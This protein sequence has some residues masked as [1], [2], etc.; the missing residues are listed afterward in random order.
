MNSFIE[1][2]RSN[3]VAR[4]SFALLVPAL[5]LA[6]GIA[7]GIGAARA[8]SYLETRSLWFSVPPPPSEA[9]GLIG[10]GSGCVYVNAVD[11][12][13]HYYCESRD[14]SEGIWDR[15]DEPPSIL[16]GS[17]TEDVFPE[18]P[19]GT[20]EVVE[21]CFGNEFLDASSFALLDDGTIKIY[22][23]QTTSAMGQIGRAI[24]GIILGAVAGLIVGIGVVVVALSE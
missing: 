13:L 9:I 6:V 23:F 8:I 17:C 5:F 11:G 20:I 1:F 3:R 22:R 4:I 12:E 24:G 15:L 10:A 7:T 18:T 16:A 19:R 2:V 21:H 14:G